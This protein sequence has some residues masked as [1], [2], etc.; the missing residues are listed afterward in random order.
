MSGCGIFSCCQ[1]FHKKF[2]ITKEN[3]GDKLVVTLVG[4]K[5]DIEKLDKKIAAFHVLAEDCCGDKGSCC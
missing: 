2:K 1:G 3:Q 5:D 4:T